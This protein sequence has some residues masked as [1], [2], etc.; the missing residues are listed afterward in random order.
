MYNRLWSKP[1]LNNC[2]FSGNLAGYGGGIF[3]TEEGCSTLNNCTFSD[4]TAREKGGGIYCEQRS[5]LTITNSILWSNNAPDGPQI[6]LD[7]PHYNNCL[8]Y[9]DIQGGVD[10]IYVDPDYSLNCGQ[11]NIDADPRFVERGYWADANDP[12]I[13]VDP[14]DP[15]AVW[16]DGDYHLLPDFPCIDAGDPNYIAEP[17]ETDLDGNPRVSGD[18][19]DM[20]AYETII[21]EA[22]LVLLPRVLN[23]KSSQSRIMARLL[24]PE[25]LTKDQ[26]DRGAP[27]LLYPGGIE[28]TRQFVFQNRRRGDER[29]S[30]FAFFDKAELMDAIPAS[31]RVE[32]QVL[33]YL[34]EPGQYFYGTDTI[35]IIAKHS[36]P[37]PH[38]SKPRHRRGR[39]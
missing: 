31:G 32:L 35:R 21:H 17:N 4:N 18:A 38:N 39:K 8:S 9:T 25:G 1:T 7:H 33:G 14:N 30:V 20:G 22:R 37:Q 5:E 23:R 15:N 19:I 6:Y 28:A 12:N 26:I 36:K 34:I 3:C 16:V 10:N 27:L 29:I 24:L 13:I 11:G 2:L